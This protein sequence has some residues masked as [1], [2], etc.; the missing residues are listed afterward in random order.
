MERRTDL[1][2]TASQTVGPYFALALPW[3]EGPYVV[4]AD[5]SDAIW[6]RGVV[7]DGIGDPIP[8]AL[9]E[10][11]QADADGSFPEQPDAAFRGFGRCPTDDGG[12]YGICTIKPAAVAGPG[13]ATA[14]P[15]ILVAVFMRGLLRP[16]ITRL[17]FPDEAANAHDPVLSSIPEPE[18]STMVATKAEDGYQFDIRLQ[19]EG[20]TAF[21]DL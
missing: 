1:F 4:S 14:A 16:V 2:P 18:R 15:Y 3:P 10:T 5:H 13:G 8:D 21:F 9:I 11:W 19:G 6:I 17:Y 20:Q 12:T 7:T